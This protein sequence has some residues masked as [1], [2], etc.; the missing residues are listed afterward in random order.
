MIVVLLWAVVTLFFYAWSLTFDLRTISDMPQRSSVYDKDGKFYSR[1]AGENRVV[2]PFD[3]VSNYFVNAVLAREDTRFYYHHG[4]DPDRH[5]TRR[6]PEFRRGRI[7]RGGEHA[8]A[9][10][11]AQQF[12]AWAGRTSFAR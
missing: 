3:K 9:A 12:P 10:A 7:S 4:V 2:V 1:L 6:C 8:D 11:C 5:C